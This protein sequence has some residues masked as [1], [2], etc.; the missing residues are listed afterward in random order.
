MATNTKRRHARVTDPRVPG[1][2]Y[3][4]GYWQDTYTVETMASALDGTVWLTVRWADG[5]R[6]THATAWDA[7]ADRVL[8][9]A[10]EAGT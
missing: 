8:Q 3:R 7:R 6:T 2:T 1:G 5:H 4:S 10:R 9:A